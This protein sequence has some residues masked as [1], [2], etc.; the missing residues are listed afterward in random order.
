MFIFSNYVGILFPMIIMGI[1]KFR[2]IR[3]ITIAAIV[4]VVGLW[5]NRY[6]IIVPTLETPYLPIQDIRSAWIH[7]KPTWVEW[8]LFIAG[9][10]D[11]AMLFML[12]SKLVPIISISE[13]EE[14]HE[15]E[16]DI[17]KQVQTENL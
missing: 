3:N 16:V 8:S 1:K 14:A 9:V 17:A 5:F 13:M 12:S 6:L 2:T 4:A 15:E 10:C 11:F 7:Y